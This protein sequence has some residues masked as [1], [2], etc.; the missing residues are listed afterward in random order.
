MSRGL[1]CI[2]LAFL[3]VPS[4]AAG[5]LLLQTSVRFDAGE[6]FT[7]SSLLIDGQLYLEVQDL[8]KQMSW[9][10]SDSP[11]ARTIFVAGK[12]ITDLVRHERRTYARVEALASALGYRS[13]VRERGNVVDFSTARKVDAPT[14]QVSIVKNRKSPSPVPD[15]QAHLIS[16]S[17]RNLSTEPVIVQTRS[18]YLKDKG[19]GKHRCETSSR[20]TVGAGEMLKIENLTFNLPSRATAEALILED[21]RGNVLAQARW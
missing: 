20:L 11:G 13:Q 9:S 6:S 5:E 17:L 16:L 14:I 7:V 4:F 3:T 12:P 1:W 15:H 21:E 19:G 2:L 8:G 10:I 18:F